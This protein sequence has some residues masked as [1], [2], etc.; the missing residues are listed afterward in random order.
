MDFRIE[1]DNHQG[2]NL[3]A[4]IETGPTVLAVA[5]A[6]DQERKEKGSRGPF[7]GI[8][9]LLK[10]STAPMILEHT[11]GEIGAHILR[12]RRIISQRMSSWE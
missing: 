5:S 4:V 2:L 8:P 6:L 11:E 10:V 1:K 9:I 12:F 3:R 7:H